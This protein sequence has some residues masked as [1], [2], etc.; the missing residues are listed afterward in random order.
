L[1]LGVTMQIGESLDQ[2]YMEQA[3]V[4]LAGVLRARPGGNN[5]WCDH[6]TNKGE[7]Y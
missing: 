2:C 5:R 3:L 4:L 6:N 7:G 1:V